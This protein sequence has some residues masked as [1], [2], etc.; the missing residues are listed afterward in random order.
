MRVKFE[1]A[2][3]G[4]G[5]GLLPANVYRMAGPVTATESQFAIVTILLAS[6][7]AP[8][9]DLVTKI[10]TETN[11]SLKQLVQYCHGTCH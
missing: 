11:L 6:C 4:G 5:G 7:L 10:C 3:V 9:V 1:W 2:R 8:R